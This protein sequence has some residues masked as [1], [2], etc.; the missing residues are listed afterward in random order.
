MKKLL[1]LASLMMS[2]SAFAYTSG[3][4]IIFQGQSANVSAVYNKTL[5]HDGENYYASVTICAEWEHS[6]SDDRSTC[7]QRITVDAVQ[8]MTS[9]RQRCAKVAS[10]SS[11]NSCDLYE[12]VEFFQS[13]VRTV[14][15]F[16][17]TGSSDNPR[18][19]K[20]ETVVIPNC[21]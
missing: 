8:P 19:Y 3:D 18:P 16:P 13:P 2:A 9:T 5:C 17:N 15:F 14:K 12:T 20:T 1:I 10:D 21:Q 4:K 6:N 7:V 11:S